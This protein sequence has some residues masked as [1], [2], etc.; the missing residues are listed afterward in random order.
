M[1]F[2]MKTYTGSC[3]CGAVTFSIEGDIES[4]LSCNCS[5]CSRKGMLLAFFPETQFSLLSGED[6]LTEYRFNKKVIAHLFC[7]TCGVQSFG[8]A[9]NKDGVPTVAIN[10][11]C[12]EG[13]N[14]ETLPITKVNG[15]DF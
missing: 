5:H 7:K 3:H 11:H 13:I 6:N 12:I 15:K 2:R 10:L 4:G 9:T 8:K 14:L 1:I